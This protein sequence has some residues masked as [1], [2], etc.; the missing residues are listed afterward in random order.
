[1][2][3][4]SRAPCDVII[5][6]GDKGKERGGAFLPDTI[7]NTMEA[8]CFLLGR[9][10]MDLGMLCAF[11]RKCASVQFFYERSFLEDESKDTRQALQACWFKRCSYQSVMFVTGRYLFKNVISNHYKLIRGDDR[12][13]Y[14]QLGCEIQVRSPSQ[15]H[16]KTD[17]TLTQIPM[18]SLE[19]VINQPCV[20]LDRVSRLEYS[21]RSQEIQTRNVLIVRWHF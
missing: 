14:H 4:S 12:F 20:L 11:K 15:G 13:Y 2:S 16:T 3:R 9:K 17:E 5:T 21:G 6:L 10:R 7:S 19:S 18:D 1:M 8:H